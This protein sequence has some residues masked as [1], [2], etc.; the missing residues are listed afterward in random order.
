MEVRGTGLC[1]GVQLEPA[2]RAGAAVR[3]ALQSG[4][5][6]LQSGRN[7]DVIAITPPLVIGETELNH[8][9]DVLATVLSDVR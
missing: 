5:I 8:A 6:F 7:G 1:W 3:Q 9:I 2:A 4:V